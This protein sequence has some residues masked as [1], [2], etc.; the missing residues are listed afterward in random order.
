MTNINDEL[1]DFQKKVL[2][3]YVTAKALKDGSDKIN[4]GREKESN[5]CLF[6]PFSTLADLFVSKI[7]AR[8]RRKRNYAENEREAGELLRQKEISDRICEMVG[9]INRNEILTEDNFVNE[10][11]EALYRSDL[12]TRFVIPEN[13][14][15][16]AMMAA[17]VFN[18]GLENFCNDKK[19]D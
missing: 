5:G 9:N 19:G 3:E 18:V 15:L 4:K 8:E 17:Q 13:A 11:T 12:A 14:V 2:S 7:L 10:L 16:Y 1:T 6:F